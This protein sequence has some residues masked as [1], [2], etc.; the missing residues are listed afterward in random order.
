MSEFVCPR[1]PTFYSI[2]PDAHVAPGEVTRPRNLANLYTLA[3]VARAFRYAAAKRVSRVSNLHNIVDV[4]AFCAG[5]DFVL[6]QIF[7]QHVARFSTT[8]PPVT[9]PLATCDVLCIC[10]FVKLFI[11]SARQQLF[12][13]GAVS[14]RL[15]GFAKDRS[16][17]PG[18]L[19]YVCGCITTS[20]WLLCTMI[21]LTPRSLAL[22]NVARVPHRCV[23]HTV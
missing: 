3:E 1:I 16:P 8:N 14:G 4:G 17:S 5:F 2:K 18:S 6:F 22:G 13:G 11:A 19:Y 9:T 10:K 12:L 20:L 21:M 7:M 23:H 15:R